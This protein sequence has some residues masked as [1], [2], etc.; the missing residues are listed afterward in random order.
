MRPGSGKG[1]VFLSLDTNLQ[2]LSLPGREICPWDALRAVL[3]M[4][5]GAAPASGLFPGNIA[6]PLNPLFG[7][8]LEEVSL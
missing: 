6:G 5:R 1:L 3:G 8:K 7:H 4:I 2:R